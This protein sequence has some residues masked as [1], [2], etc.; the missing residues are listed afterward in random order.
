MEPMLQVCET[1][2][3]DVRSALCVIRDSSGA[4]L[5]I[6][7]RPSAKKSVTTFVTANPAFSG[8][9]RTTVTVDRVIYR[10]DKTYRKFEVSVAARFGDDDVPFVFDLADPRDADV[11]RR[12][13]KLVVDL[14]AFSYDAEVYADE[15]AYNRAQS[16][17]ENKV[18][19]ASNFF[20]PSGAFLESAGGMANEEGPTAYADFAGHVIKAELRT[21]TTGRAKFWWALVKTYSGAMID[22]VLDPTALNREPQVGAVITGRFWL[23]ARLAVEH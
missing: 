14:A 13:A 21:N 6:G 20:I 17:P 10:K 18:R 11:F 8:E 7:L 16:E 15:A 5:W 1:I 3:I 23:S 2:E 19:F 12:G 4:E 22:V 9:G